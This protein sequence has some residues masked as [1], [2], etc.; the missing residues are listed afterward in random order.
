MEKT[1]FRPIV[2]A[3]EYIGKLA[4]ML[5]TALSYFARLSVDFRMTIFH[6]SNLGINSIPITLLVVGFTG[7]ILSVQ[8]TEQAVRFGT[9]QFIGGG[10]AFVMVR[11]LAPVLTAV[12]MAGRVGSSIAS[13]LG[14]MKVTE[15]I[16]ALRSLAV[17]PIQ[18][19][20][21]PRMLALMIM[22][23]TVT[24]IAG[25]T[26]IMAAYMVAHQVYGVNWEVFYSYIPRLVEQ[27]DVSAAMLKSGLF[28]ITI[29][30]I[31][32]VEGMHTEGGA[33]GVGKATTNAVV[34][35]IV[36]IF[37]LNYAL[38]VLLF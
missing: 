31:G 34:A 17:N 38:T 28:A 3:V 4:G 33:S 35:S 6:M 26:G 25:L 7:M 11:E 13:E 1:A 9:T 12:V 24:V 21:A 30:L 10:I 22:I 18:Y 16:D 37:A 8:I 5:A 15:Q 2:S 29:A 36:S 20:V 14:S 19:L 32:C 23:P 27:R